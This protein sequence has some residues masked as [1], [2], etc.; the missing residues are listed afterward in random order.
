METAQEINSR[1]EVSVLV[2]T[3]YGKVRTNPI[4]GPVFNGIVEDWDSHLERLTDFWEMVLLHSG[5]GAGKF[6]PVPVHKEVDVKMDHQIQEVHFNTWLTLWFETID[7]LFKGEVAEYAKQHA[8]K[9]GHILF[10]KI[11][12]GR[13][14]QA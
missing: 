8:H 6:S 2:K 10:F 12:E 9:M 14:N 13:K 11:M 7:M 3:F 4:L 5:P 1:V